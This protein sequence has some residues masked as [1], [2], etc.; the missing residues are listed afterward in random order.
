M[1]WNITQHVA[2]AEQV[3]DSVIDLPMD[4]REELTRLL[5]IEEPD[6]EEILEKVEGIVALAKTLEPKGALMLGGAPFMMPLLEKRL[7]EEGFF[8]LYAFSKRESVEVH[9]PDG[10]V[11]KKA[12][13]KH[14]GFIPGLLQG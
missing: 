11:E 5:T 9:H 14:A 12:V 8:V 10:R 7:I 6:P 2:T 13:F 3:L 4:K 1:I